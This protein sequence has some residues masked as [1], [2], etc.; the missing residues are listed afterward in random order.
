MWASVAIWIGRVI[1]GRP[2]V[3]RDSRSRAG[4]E[5]A[6][7]TRVAGYAAGSPTSNGSMV[8]TRS[9]VIGGAADARD[10]ARSWPARTPKGPNRSG[11]ALREQNR[12]GA[13]GVSRGLPRLASD[14]TQVV[15]GLESCANHFR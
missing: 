15:R 3:A 4:R 12:V 7:T 2:A 1:A 8:S 6:R 9:D 13:L 14:E 11:S 5:H 10:L